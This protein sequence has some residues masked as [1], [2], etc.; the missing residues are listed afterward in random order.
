[1]TEQP[2]KAFLYGSCV[3]R[4]MYEMVGKSHRL[5]RLETIAR[6]SLV[7][8]FHPA[9]MDG[10]N[11]KK[12]KSPFQQRMA[13]RDFEGSLLKALDR[14]KDTLDVIIIDLVDE[15]RGVMKYP[16]G[17]TF[18]R[19]R[20]NESALIGRYEDL[21]AEYLEFESDSFYGAFAR[22]AVAFKKVLTKYGL[23]EKT[24]ILDIPLALT[25]DSKDPN[26]DTQRAEDHLQWA[27]R[28]NDQLLNLYE[29]LDALG[30]T[31]AGLSNLQPLMSSTHK[32]G[33]APFHYQD[34]TYELIHDAVMTFAEAISN[35]RTQE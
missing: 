26:I 1:M 18:T 23:L 35:P 24:I 19:S 28:M 15:R 34:S 20:E 8:A 9:P 32:W 29:L 14:Q 7:S 16:G 30:F 6:Q 17:A 2:I 25:Y 22:E 12:I 21:G 13:L 5:E 31:T 11:L 4:D 27:P 3:G 10:F 33:Q